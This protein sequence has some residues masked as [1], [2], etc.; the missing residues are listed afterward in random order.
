MWHSVYVVPHY[1]MVCPQPTHHLNYIL[2]FIM[3]L[4]HKIE[5]CLTK[6]RLFKIFSLTH[7]VLPLMTKFVSVAFGY[8]NLIF[9]QF[10]NLTSY[11]IWGNSS[12]FEQ[13]TL[14]EAYHHHFVRQTDFF[15][16]FFKR[17]IKIQIFPW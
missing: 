9:I 4:P 15:N 16:L 14:C 12:N 2:S 17:L 7:Y 6:C 8:T 13:P 1:R 3:D 5:V 11:V 10:R